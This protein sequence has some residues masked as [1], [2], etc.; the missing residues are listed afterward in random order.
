MSIF[1]HISALW[2]PHWDA[3]LYIFFHIASFVQLKLSRFE[4]KVVEKSNFGG[5]L[6]R[7]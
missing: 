3:D 7:L 1:Y 4:K 6:K 5:V 2:I